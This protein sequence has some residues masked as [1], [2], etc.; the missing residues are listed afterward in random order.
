M[1][2]SGSFWQCLLI[3]LLLLSACNNKSV[4]KPTELV[5]IKVASE[6]RLRIA[7]I[8]E[9]P[10]IIE[11]EQCDSCL[12]GDINKV[13]KDDS[14]FYILDRN[15]AEA[16]FKFDLEGNF[17]F[18]I[19]TKGEG[20][21]QFKLPFDFDL[22]ENGVELFILDMNSRKFLVFDKTTGSFIREFSYSTFQVENFI[23]FS[24]DL[25]A[26]E[27]DGR[28]T[29]S[30]KENL[31]HIVNFT[32]ND[33]IFKGILDYPKTVVM[34]YG[35]EFTKSSHSFLFSRAL[36]DTIYTVL[37]NEFKPKYFLDFGNRK[38]STELKV[39]DIMELGQGIQKEASFFSLG[40]NFENSKYLIFNWVNEKEYEQNGIYFKGKNEFYQLVSENSLFRNPF[41]MDEESV[42]TF[43]SNTDRNFSPL[44]N[45]YIQ[46]ENFYLAR[47]LFKD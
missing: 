29:V 14:G 4:E 27:V 8:F 30:E 31:G 47:F 45:E 44:P 35:Q 28:N 26:V 32:L 1:I 3:A 37:E 18:K 21:G 2:K 15:R 33:T 43:Y 25:F 11:L 17:I 46:K 20:P 7:D 34:F 16:I 6:N 5:T 22:L 40:R 39:L 13:V 10:E 38:V 23:A 24:K 19:D 41:F 12:M 36:N 9:E 42:F